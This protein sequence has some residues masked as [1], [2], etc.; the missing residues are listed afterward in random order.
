[1]NSARSA[2]LD[3]HNSSWQPLAM[4]THMLDVTLFGLDGGMHH[5]LNFLLHLANGVLLYAALVLM[6]GNRVP[7]ALVALLFAI[8]PLHVEPVAWISSRKDVLSTTFLFLT[9]VAYARYAKA[10]TVGQMV[11]VCVLFALGL[12]SKPMVITLPFLLLLLDYWPLNRLKSPYDAR[13]LVLEKIPLFV[14]CALGI[15]ATLYFQNVGGAIKS[16]EEYPLSTR[17]PASIWAYYQ[18]IAHTFAPVELSIL[19][20]HPLGSL[21]ALQVTLASLVL[22]VVS[23][24]ALATIRTRP[25][26]FVGW[27]WFLGTLVPVIGIVQ[28]GGHFMADRYTYISLIGLFVAIAWAVRDASLRNPDS[29]GSHAAIWGVIFAVLIV[30]TFIQVPVWKNSVTVF[31]E[32]VANTANNPLAHNNLGRAYQDANRAEEA[33]REFETALE[34]LPGLYIA[35]SNLALVKL[36]QGEYAAAEVDLKEALNYNDTDPRVWTNLGISYGARNLHAQ[37]EDAFRQATQADP[38]YLPA[39]FNLALAQKMQGNTA[40]ARQT[41]QEL[42]NTAPTYPGAQDQL[43]TLQN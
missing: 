7:S 19:Y 36:E 9:F 5:L 1:M 42:L 16:A 10:P 21:G 34:L 4:V 25:Y 23:G 2:F 17:I 28:F 11:G 43:N 22:L 40:D 27:C 38:T 29:A 8:H 18:Y 6:T 30:L 20:P 39:K 37:A 12:L 14:I 41:L 35:R 31:E 26:V 15:A 3:A 13:N 32:A 24:I 33:I